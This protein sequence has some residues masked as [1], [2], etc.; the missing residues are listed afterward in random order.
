MTREEAIESLKTMDFKELK[1]V[2]FPKKTRWQKI[3]SALGFWSYCEYIGEQEYHTF[4]WNW[5]PHGRY[6][7]KFDLFKYKVRK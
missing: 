6:Y 4:Y 7:R 3:Y 5:L 2:F 1:K